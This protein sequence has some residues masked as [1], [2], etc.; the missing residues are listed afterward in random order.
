[1]K[2]KELIEIIRLA[3]RQELKESLPTIIKEC[4]KLPVSTRVRKKSTKE[5]DPVELTKQVLKTESKVAS[6][7]K[8]NTIQ[9]TKNTALNEAL[10]ATVGGVP[11]EGGRVLNDP[12]MGNQT[13]E[14]ITDFNGNEVGVED[15]PD[16]LAKALTRDYSDLMGA[17][18]KKKGVNT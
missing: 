10:N 4:G 7:S 14:A 8:N 5:I 16:P 11:Q 6:L 9:Y 3:V 17:I 1:M 13:T 2:K 18:N 15:L 12:A